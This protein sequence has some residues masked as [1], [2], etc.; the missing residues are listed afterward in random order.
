MDSKTVEQPTGHVKWVTLIMLTIVYSVSYID[1]QLLL[2]LAEPIKNDLGL[3][4]TQIGLL[5]GFSFALL[6]TMAG[7]PI[8]W[9][10]DRSN[11]V[12]IVAAA[13]ALWSLFST[14]CGF[15]GN[16]VQLAIARMGVGIGEAGGTA[17]SLSILSD[18]FPPN[19]R[20]KT[21]SLYL[22]GSPLGVFVGTAAGAALAQAYGWRTAFI[23][24]SLP[25][26][27]LAG[28]IWILIK[29]PVRGR[30]DPDGTDETS[31]LS[32]LQTLLVV[33]K[34]QAVLWIALS[35]GASA[36][37]VHGFNAWLPAFLMREKGMS[38]GDISQY[39][40]VM[41]SG[42]VVLGML[43]SAFVIDRFA[44]KDQ[45]AYAVIPAFGLMLALPCFVGAV[46]VDDWRISLALLV[47]PLAATSAQ[48]PPAIALVHNRVAAAQR[49]SASAGFLL[50]LNLIG[51]GFGPVF[52]GVISDQALAI[53]IRDSLK[54]GLLSVSAL[55]IVPI[56]LLFWTARV[57]GVTSENNSKVT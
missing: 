23:A 44:S 20:G 51:L 13:C 7:I 11:R 41:A 47:I 1:R 9:L 15:A 10:A 30:S 2:V 38:L 21:A 53:G 8:A 3:S 16:F 28:L 45:R 18:L 46:L 14:A 57:I 50:I 36:F 54:V 19:Q 56:L 40:S 39:F 55:L 12:R 27:V 17:P 4:D 29:E 42:S 49:A 35:S 32:M 25:G 5:G 31:A 52:V 22:L 33:F 34:N 43:T 6:Y 24:L 48:V 26:L 37:V